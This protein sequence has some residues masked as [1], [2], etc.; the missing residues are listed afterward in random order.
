[1]AFSQHRRGDGASRVERRG[2]G[3]RETVLVVVSIMQV[4]IRADGWW[5]RPLQLGLEAVGRQ[6]RGYGVWRSGEVGGMA[7]HRDTPGRYS[8]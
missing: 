2:C 4:E 5:A 6:I 8:S 1:M 7:C 3:T